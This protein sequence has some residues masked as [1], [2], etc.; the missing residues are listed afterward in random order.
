MDKCL[1]GNTNRSVF[2]YFC[3]LYIISRIRSKPYD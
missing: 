3:P 1:K 2:M